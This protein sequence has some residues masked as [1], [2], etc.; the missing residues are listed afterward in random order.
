M[1]LLTQHDPTNNNMSSLAP[2][3]T[4]PAS[5]SA[6]TPIAR[7]DPAIS[8]EKINVEISTTVLPPCPIVMQK[9]YCPA[10]LVGCRIV[11]ERENDLRYK[12]ALAA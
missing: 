9:T 10:N 1:S 11:S 4:A 6:H 3:V 7:N 2:N 12:S 5:Y 8:I